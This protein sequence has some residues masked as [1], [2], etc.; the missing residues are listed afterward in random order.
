MALAQESE[1]VPWNTVG[2]QPSSCPG[3][4]PEMTLIDTLVAIRGDWR[5][6]VAQPT[7]RSTAREPAMV[8]NSRTVEFP[9]A[10]TAQ[11]EGLCAS[12]A[13]VFDLPHLRYGLADLTS[14]FHE[15]RIACFFGLLHDLI[16]LRID[17]LLPFCR[18]LVFGNG[19]RWARRLPGLL[20]HDPPWP[21][22][23][24]GHCE[25]YEKNHHTDV[26]HDHPPFL[27]DQLLS[28]TLTLRLRYRSSSLTK[29]PRGCGEYH[30]PSR[31]SSRC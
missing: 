20:R 13:A 15:T 16:Q 5:T 8:S 12:I 9:S 27:Q 11:N 6:A 28:D 19:S 29:E 1:P 22:A 18:H 2:R 24:C 4:P 21:Q 26:S 30:R 7:G 14:E 10:P 31:V 25:H 17:R 23:N 3:L